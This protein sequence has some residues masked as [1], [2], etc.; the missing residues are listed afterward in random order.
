MYMEKT[1]TS[2]GNLSINT[3][4][5][6]TVLCNVFKEAY[7]KSLQYYGIEREY[8]DY[9]VLLL[10]LESNVNSESRNGSTDCGCKH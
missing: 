10:N 8:Q 3:L 2:L 9:Y 7:K 6:T 5:N 1:V 4:K